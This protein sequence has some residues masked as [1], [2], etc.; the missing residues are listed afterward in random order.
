MGLINLP[1]LLTQEDLSKDS[2]YS[3]LGISGYG[4]VP[5]VFSLASDQSDWRSALL[6]ANVWLKLAQ[7]AVLL[8]MMTFLMPLTSLVVVQLG[9]LV[10]GSTTNLRFAKR[11]A[12]VHAAA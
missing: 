9:N 11:Q 2:T 10:L 5:R 12:Q 4:E 1:F 8:I 6:T 3:I 7:V